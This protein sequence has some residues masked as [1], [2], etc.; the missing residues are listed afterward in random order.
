[1]S[2]NIGESPILEAPGNGLPLI[3]AFFGRW[4]LFPVASTFMSQTQAIQMLL[5][6]GKVAL[7]LAQ[8]LPDEALTRPV[9]IPKITGIEDSSRFWSVAMTIEHLLITGEGMAQ[10]IETLAK[11]EIPQSTVR[12]A[13]VKPQ[14]DTKTTQGKLQAYQGFL[15]KYSGRM[16]RLT[17]LKD[18]RFRH[19][20]PWFWDLT[21]H[22][23]LC[24]NALHHRIHLN[25]IQQIIQRLA[26]NPN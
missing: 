1:M 17:N 23:W 9:L 5:D 19:Y 15:E 18:R 2:D 24:L 7:A 11:G 6:Q 25:Q 22:Q 4:L 20:H 10:T 16:Q 13:D 3:E 12:I 26:I 21:A 14:G 8:A